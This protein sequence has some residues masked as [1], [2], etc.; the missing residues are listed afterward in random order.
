MKNI[1][2]GVASTFDK[3]K[4]AVADTYSGLKKDDFDKIL[5]QIEKLSKLLENGIIT[6]EEFEAKKKEWLSKI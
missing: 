4:N 6:Q 3:L 1:G 5:E 2:A